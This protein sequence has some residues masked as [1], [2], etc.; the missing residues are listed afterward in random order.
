MRLRGIL[1]TVVV[2]ASLLLAVLNMEVLTT[3]VPLD[4]ALVRT[5]FPLGLALLIA[6]MAVAVVFFLAA[7]LDRA[8]QLRQ[9]TQIERQADALRQRLASYELGEGQR[10]EER[11][12]AATATLEERLDDVTRGVRER[13]D[14]GIVELGTDLRAR[15]DELEARDVA[16]HDALRERID[17]LRNE[18]AADVA[19][20]EDTLLRRLP[21]AGHDEGDV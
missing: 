5:S 14:A 2:V 8:E 3:P 17:V 12:M 18:L 1:L 11:L 15:L 6:V 4:L 16:R 13:V 7:L 19:Q 20:T 21:E 10:V 9:L